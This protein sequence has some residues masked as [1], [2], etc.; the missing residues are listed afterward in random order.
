MTKEE[1][2]Q[3]RTSRAWWGHVRRDPAALLRWLVRQYRGE[4]TAAARIEL[5]R[6]THARPGSRAA[7][8][9][10]RIASDERRHARWVGELLTTRGQPL[11]VCAEP[12]RYWEAPL[13]GIRDLETGCAVGAHAEA[14][15][16][17]RIE[18][19][20]A[21][22]TAPADI[23]AVFRRILPE[24]RVHAAA[25]AQLASA[26]ALEATRGAHELGRRALGLVV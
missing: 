18:V 11:D 14:M 17:E 9:L 16:L 23:R 3:A 26:E 20:C 21:D 8:V 2:P 1:M 6:D 22:E 12:D 24:E 19:I 15:R 5:L 7:R 25:F 10:T 13:A 4:V